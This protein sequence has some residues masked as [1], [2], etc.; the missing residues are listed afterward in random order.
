MWLMVHFNGE[1]EVLHVALFVLDHHVNY[2]ANELY[3]H[4]RLSEL[5]NTLRMSD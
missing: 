4:V 1:T 5:I 2:A 3:P